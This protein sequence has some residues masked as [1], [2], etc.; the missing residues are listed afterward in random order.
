MAVPDNN[1]DIY[2][3]PRVA[4]DVFK[5][6]MSPETYASGSNFSMFTYDDGSM[7]LY[8]YV[9]GDVRPSHVRINTIKKVSALTDTETGRRVLVDAVKIAEDFE[10]RTYYS[11]DIILQPGIFHK[12]K[13]E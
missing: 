6:M 1:A 9:K 13:F 2:R 7:I 4:T 5:R 8:R 12:L 11:A 10:E 3:I